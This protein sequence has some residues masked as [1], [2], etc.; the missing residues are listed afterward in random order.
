MGARQ[1]DGVCDSHQASGVA[2]SSKMA[3]VQVAKWSVAMALIGANTP[4]RS[5][6]AALKQ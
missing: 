4:S 5:V 6:L 2:K 1:R 3:V